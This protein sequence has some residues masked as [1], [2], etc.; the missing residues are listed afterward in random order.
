MNSLKP[1]QPCL[2]VPGLSRRHRRPD[3]QDRNCS[4]L[5]EGAWVRRSRAPEST[6][7]DSRELF[8]FECT[9]PAQSIINLV[10][11]SGGG[12]GESC[13]TEPS[14]GS[15]PTANSESSSALE[16]TWSSA[17]APVEC[18]FCGAAVFNQQIKLTAEPQRRLYG[19]TGC[20]AV[21]IAVLLF[22]QQPSTNA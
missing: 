16:R 5:P 15:D 11:G 21:A 18:F 14:V 22:P 13:S 6:E 19:E 1:F 2:R 17:P 8:A 20:A 12:G 9:L 7:R 10:H 4:H 3:L